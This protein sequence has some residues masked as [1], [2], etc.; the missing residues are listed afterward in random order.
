M[1]NLQAGYAPGAEALRPTVTPNFQ[2]VQPQSVE[3]RLSGDKAF[4]LADALGS[5]NATIQKYAEKKEAELA[6]EQARKIPWYVEQYKKDWDSGAVSQAQVRER[7]PETV[8]VI[9][10]RISEAM[11]STAGEEAFKPVLQ[12]I[13]ENDTLRFNTEARKAFIDERK[14]N[15]TAGL[16]GQGNDF[17]S[18]GFIKAVDAANSQFENQFAQETAKYQQKVQEEDFTKQIS[19]AFLNGGSIEDIDSAFNKSSS[20][21]N[22]TRK[23]LIVKSVADLAYSYDDPTMLTKIPQKYLNAELKGDIADAQTKIQGQRIAKFNY[24]RS[25]EGY[26][27]EQKTRKNK[28]EMITDVMDGKTLD[29]AKYRGDVDSYNYALS[30][31]NSPRLP[32]AT[33]AA[34]AEKVRAGILNDATI[35][36]TG[37]ANDFI[38]AIH[39]NPDLNPADKVKL[40]NEMPK[41]IEG[42]LAMKDEAVSSALSLRINPRLES[43]EKSTNATIQTLLEGRNLRSEVMKT[44]D[45]GIR[46]SFQAEFQDTGKWPTG[47]RKLELIDKQ[48]EKAE[49]LLESLTRISPAEPKAANPAPAAAPPPANPAPASKSPKGKKVP[50][51]GM[52]GVYRYE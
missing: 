20:I 25:I 34:N 3:S 36:N 51:P 48:V 31:M 35:G 5:A 40:I 47:H 23:K 16:G 24:A 6:T 7:F 42:N 4:Q 52:P 1:A 50:V 43:L 11:G 9:A 46:S 38:D 10:S 45:Q 49:K 37:S 22:L 28:L 8:P 41:L 30:V 32:E 13:L 18:A 33:S 19:T 2:M 39:T 21:D 14:A 15:I 27:R 17:Y 44:F 26:E 29:P 12:E